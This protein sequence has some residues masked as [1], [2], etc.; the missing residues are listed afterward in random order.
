MLLFIFIKHKLYLTYNITVGIIYWFINKRS[1]STRSVNN[2]FNHLKRFA[3]ADICKLYYVV[4]AFAWLNL[5]VSIVFRKNSECNSLSPIDIKTRKFNSNRFENTSDRIN[6]LT[7]IFS[8]LPSSSRIHIP[9]G[10]QVEGNSNCSS[11]NNITT[12]MTGGCSIV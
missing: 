9:F 11:C 8:G 1:R 10:M 12:T 3:F 7:T 5:K 2:I 6:I 4:W